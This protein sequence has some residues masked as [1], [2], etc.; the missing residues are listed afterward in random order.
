MSF[1]ISIEFRGRYLHVKLPPD[2]KITPESVAKLWAIIGSACQKYDRNRVLVEG[3]IASR[4]MTAGDAYYSGKKAGG[5]A[6]LRL[7]CLFYGYSPD[8][9][10]DFFKIV[11]LNR[12]VLV[13]FFTDRTK[14]LQ[15]LGVDSDE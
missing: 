13:E 4:K 10:T 3:T 2:Y 7:A 6:H 8:E 12:G 5:I 1:D 11:A 15:W 14:A 9:T